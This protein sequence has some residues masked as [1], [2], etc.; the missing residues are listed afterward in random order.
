MFLQK[1][2]EMQPSTT[3]RSP[4]RIYSL[5]AS[6]SELLMVFAFKQAFDLPYNF[7]SEELSKVHY[8]T[9]MINELPD[10]GLIQVLEQN[11]EYILK[12][13]HETYQEY[14]TALYILKGLVNSKG[15]SYEVAKN[16]IIDNCYRSKYRMIMIISA[17]LSLSGD[18]IIPGWSRDNTKQIR[19]FWH[20]LST[21]DDILE[22]A[23]SKLLRDCL[24]GL[25]PD[26]IEKLKC[27]VERETWAD[28]LMRE[29]SKI[30]EINEADKPSGKESVTEEEPSQSIEIL[31]QNTDIDLPFDT[32]SYCLEETL[33]VQP[34]F[35][36]R[37]KTQ[38][39]NDLKYKEQVLQKT[40]DYLE[41]IN[42]KFIAELFY[43][44]INDK[45]SPLNSYW[46]IDGGFQAMALLSNHFN[47]YLADYFIE[48]INSD[49]SWLV[50]PAF[51][52]ISTLLKQNPKGEAKKACIDV[53]ICL[54]ENSV[55][56]RSGNELFVMLRASSQLIIESLITKLKSQ[57][58]FAEIKNVVKIINFS[59][60]DLFEQPIKSFLNILLVALKMGYAVFINKDYNKINFFGDS[61]IEFKLEDDEMS[62]IFSE[63]IKEISL[64]LKKEKD[65]EALLTT[66]KGK[67]DAVILK[68]LNIKYD[69]EILAIL[70]GNREI[71]QEVFT[72]N[73]SNT[74]GGS[75]N[76]RVMKEAQSGSYVRSLYYKLATYNLITEL[77]VEMFTQE[78][79]TAKATY[80]GSYWPIS[81]SIAATQYL[82]K[83]FNDEV[84]DFLIMRAG[85]WND[86]EAEA[87]KAL[88]EIKKSLDKC[89]EHD[90]HYTSALAAYNKTAQALGIQTIDE[91]TTVEDKTKQFL[92]AI[93]HNN[94]EKVMLFIEAVDINYKLEKKHNR[95]A[96]HL[97][98]L[99]GNVEIANL[100]IARGE[101]NINIQDAKGRTPLH[102]AEKY[103]RSEMVKL[104]L[105]RGANKELADIKDKKTAKDYSASS[106][107]KSFL[108]SKDTNI[109]QSSNSSGYTK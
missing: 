105:E 32:K 46:D 8:I 96:L 103:N 69:K 34:A 104:L 42:P 52:A 49:P 61:E 26:Q 27:L 51:N 6:Y 18:P 39:I 82:G 14:F 33:V 87:K 16:I 66:E 98:A 54:V 7:I 75:R 101:I 5:T 95:T 73:I 13:N 21:Q 29:I 44:I 37:K 74:D 92:K 24:H 43:E 48:K 108:E 107:I 99:Q 86:N 89:K 85:Y 84:A 63:V 91:Q 71:F 11:K 17:Q 56:F 19:T 58:T 50:Y 38:L 22:V 67:I 20:I 100:L 4:H 80:K 77:I 64:I 76:I 40:K 47:S 36:N 106:K 62:R 55:H 59:N 79:S 65:K 90:E 15:H 83:Y 88:N 3:L 72:V 109:N 31:S 23:S 2:M 35:N 60:H 68:T 97:T 12:F 1:H 53:I 94:T 30:K 45:E 57:L 102:L 70:I 81:G 41:T 9:E 78:L 28:L 25:L 93:T 10:T